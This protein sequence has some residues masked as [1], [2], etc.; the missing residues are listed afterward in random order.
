MNNTK[1]L[2]TRHSHELYK[3]A[4][5]QILIKEPIRSGVNRH[6]MTMDRLGRV[7]F[8]TNGHECE[9]KDIKIFISFILLTMYRLP[10]RTFLALHFV[11]PRPHP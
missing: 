3:G 4:R 9:N 1:K 10:P 6:S 8:R 11:A 7:V 5:I 2:G